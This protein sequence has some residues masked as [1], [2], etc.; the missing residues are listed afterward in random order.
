MSKMILPASI[1]VL[2]LGLSAP[3][4]AQQYT[5]D[6]QS[7]PEDQVQRFQEHCDTLFGAEGAGAAESTTNGGDGG[8]SGST[9]ASATAGGSAT[10]TA[11]STSGSN[12][13]DTSG[14]GTTDWST[15]DLSTL[16]AEA[17]R[18]AGFQASGG[19]AGA[20]EGSNGTGTDGSVDITTDPTT[21][22]ATSG[23]SSGSDGTSN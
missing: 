2:A 21:G 17:C 7:L 20:V 11:G 13:S 12:S 10:G 8:S 23:T 4:F 3:S 22:G 15:F 5:I 9:D 6:G 1:A 14:S 18:S 16:D 19:A